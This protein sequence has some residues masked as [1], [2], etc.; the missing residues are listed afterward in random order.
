MSP[1]LLV[2]RTFTVV[3]V[4]M[5]LLFATSQVVEIGGVHYTC[6]YHDIYYTIC[7]MTYLYACPR[8]SLPRRVVRAT[9]AA[10]GEREIV[11]TR[12]GRRSEYNRERAHETAVDRARDTA[13]PNGK[14][15][16]NAT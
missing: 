13:V 10:G 1:T 7:V 8:G 14:K 3:V 5:A 12:Y 15:T 9:V 11:D 16:T 6:I 2:F 4:I